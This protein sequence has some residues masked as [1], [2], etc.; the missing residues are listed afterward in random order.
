M[1]YTCSY[2]NKEKRKKNTLRFYTSQLDYFGFSKQPSP[3]LA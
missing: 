1:P 2:S 3:M